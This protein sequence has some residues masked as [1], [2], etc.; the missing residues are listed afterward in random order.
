MTPEVQGKE[1]KRC[2]DIVNHFPRWFGFRFIRYD[3]ALTDWAKIFEWVLFVGF[4]QV[5]KWKHGK[6]LKNEKTKTRQTNLTGLP[7]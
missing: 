3:P 5:R 2:L 6:P 1:T 4:W 7:R